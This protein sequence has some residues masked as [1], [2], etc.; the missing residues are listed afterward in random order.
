M[1][2]Y[3]SLLSPASGTVDDEPAP[4]ATAAR[5]RAI[6]QL[7]RLLSTLD[8]AIRGAMEGID[9]D[10]PWITAEVKKIIVRHGHWIVELADD[11]PDKGASARLSVRIGTHVIDA[12]SISTGI[13]VTPDMIEG[14]TLRMR[15]RLRLHP[16]HHLSAQALAIDP[17]MTQSLRAL[18]ADKLR[19]DLCELGLHDMQP[20]VAIPRDILHLAIIHPD[21]SAARSDVDA[22]LAPLIKR[23]LL[24]VDTCAVRFEGHDAAGHLGQALDDILRKTWRPRADLVL[25]VRGGGSA[26]GMADI[27][28][29]EVAEKIAR[30]PM[31][32]VIGI[33]HAPDRGILSE[34]AWKACH[35]PTAAAVAVRDMVAER[36]TKARDDALA[37]ATIGRQR[38][39]AQ[40][41]LYTDAGDAI[42]RNTFRALGDQAKQLTAHDH[43]IRLAAA[44]FDQKLVTAT[45]NIE[46]LLAELRAGLSGT[47][48]AFMQHLG[49]LAGIARTLRERRDILTLTMER[50]IACRAED[51]AQAHAAK[52]HADHVADFSGVS[53]S[54]VTVRGPDGALVTSAVHARDQP[55]TLHFHDGAVSVFSHPVEIARMTAVPTP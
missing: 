47:E 21:G 51:L 5:P 3:P 49:K 44:R 50:D 1:T 15:I 33:G 14:Q 18:A 27:E 48:N 24:L 12:L 23:G 19:R 55:L 37:V 46:A 9:Q 29:R 41:A 17:A 13:P 8:N 38:I 28:T 7:G 30:M 32:V 42:R 22:V 26:T 40:E 36:A 35:T 39:D 2:I 53:Y 11:G 25:I 31:P 6:V 34:V 20:N 10:G 45:V 16:R 43:R 4:D 54:Q 52:A